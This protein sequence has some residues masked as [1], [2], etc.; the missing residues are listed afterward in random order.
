[1]SLLLVS[2][3]VLSLAA[4]RALPFNR[5]EGWASCSIDDLDSISRSAEYPYLFAV[6][7]SQLPMESVSDLY[8]R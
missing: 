2:V 7:T 6:V 5:V 8:C 1:M 4:F 3:A